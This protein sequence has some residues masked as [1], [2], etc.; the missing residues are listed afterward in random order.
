MVAAPGLEL[1]LPR[2]ADRLADPAGDRSVRGVEP[3]LTGSLM[4]AA[5]LPAVLLGGLTAWGIFRLASLTR[6]RACRDVRGDPAA[7]DPGLRDR[8]RADHVA[9][10]R[11]SAAGPGRRCGRSGR[12]ATMT[13]RRVAAGLMGALGVMA[14]Y[15]VLA[16]PASVGRTCCSARRTAVNLVRPGFWSCRR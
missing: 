8:W 3:Q 11:W 13:S 4:F 6:A 15:S 16:L 10:R 9:I 2:A 12:S 1:L 14:K 7:G 5:R